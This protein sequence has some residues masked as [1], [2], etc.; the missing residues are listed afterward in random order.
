MNLSIRKL[1]DGAYA[2][3]TGFARYRLDISGEEGEEELVVSGP[4]FYEV[5]SCEDF[6]SDL[7][8]LAI[9]LLLIINAELSIQGV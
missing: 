1:D 9:G 4:G 3:I 2:I 7:K 6:A 8:P 5:A